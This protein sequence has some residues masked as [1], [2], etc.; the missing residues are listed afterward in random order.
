MEWM[1]ASRLNLNSFYCLKS[2]FIIKLAETFI[3]FEKCN[4]FCHK[5]SILIILNNGK[6]KDQFAK[7]T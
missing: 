1:Q 4:Q 2:R 5:T 3:Y 6:M 7:I